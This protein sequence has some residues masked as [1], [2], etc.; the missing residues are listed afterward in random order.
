MQTELE[1]S[2]MDKEEQEDILNFVLGRLATVE[3]HVK[4]LKNV[5]VKNKSN[6]IFHH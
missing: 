3:Q 2:E 6:H 4:V 5:Q 1:E